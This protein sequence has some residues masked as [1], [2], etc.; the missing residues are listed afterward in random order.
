MSETERLTTK[1]YQPGEVIFH[2]GD[3]GKHVGFFANAFSE[4]IQSL[5][6]LI[7]TVVTFA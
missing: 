3:P 4:L 1:T 5:R 2:E 7:I 6:S